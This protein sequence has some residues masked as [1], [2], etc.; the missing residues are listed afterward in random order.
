[1]QSKESNGLIFVRLFPNEDIYESLKEVCAKHNVTTAVVLSGVGQL[2]KFRL[3]Y[4][5]KKNDYAP[6]FFEEPHELLALN[7]LISKGANG[8]DFHLHAVLGNR[9]KKAIGGHLIEG[10]VEVT[11]E[12]VLLKSDAKLFRRIEEATGLAGLFVE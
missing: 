7:G 1:M 5:V 10:I 9:E 6:E 11:C 2:K 3:G 4:F 8:Y 12:L